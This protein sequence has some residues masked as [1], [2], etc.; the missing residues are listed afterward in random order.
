[1]KTQDVATP[2]L[3]SSSYIQEEQGSEYLGMGERVKSTGFNQVFCQRPLKEASTSSQSCDTFS[4][5]DI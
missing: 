4:D 3:L 2:S 5:H 1:M